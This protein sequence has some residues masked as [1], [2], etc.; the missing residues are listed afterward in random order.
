MGKVL[1]DSNVGA[2]AHTRRYGKQSPH[3]SI[4]ERFK[5]NPNRLPISNVGGTV[6]FLGRQYE[7]GKLV[8]YR[9][10]RENLQPYVDRAKAIA[11]GSSYSKHGY[12]Y[13][14]SMPRIVIDA[15]LR[16]R[17]KT[18]EDYGRDNELSDQFKKWFQSNF[19]KMLASAHQERSLAINR[20]IGGRTGSAPRLGATILDDYRKEQSNAKDGSQQNHE[21]KAA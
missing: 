6:K 16:E 18:W 12:G 2:A 7:G 9:G 20:S 14:G 11:N 21:S 3:R 13:L 17:G 5:G 4:R 15:W 10:W 19:K 8:H 1:L